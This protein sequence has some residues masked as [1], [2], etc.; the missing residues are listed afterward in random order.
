MQWWLTVFFFVNGAWVP[1]DNFAGWS[2]RAFD[3]EAHCLEHKAFAENEC[4]LH[5]LTYEAYW[6][7]TEGAPATSPPLT[8]PAID[9]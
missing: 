4:R 2:P 7:C 9:C 1:G 8:A 5:P 3:S 6:M